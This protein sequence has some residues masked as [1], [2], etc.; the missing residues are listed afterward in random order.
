MFTDNEKLRINNLSY[1]D[2]YN[3]NKESNTELKTCNSTN[4]T[5]MINRIN[6]DYN[7]NVDGNKGDERD[8]NGDEID[9]GGGDTDDGDDYFYD[10]GDEVASDNHDIDVDFHVRA[11]DS[12]ENKI[13]THFKHE[14][15]KEKI[16][17]IKPAKIEIPNFCELK[18]RFCTNTATVLYSIFP[19][20]ETL[21]AKFDKRRTQLKHNVNYNKLIEDDY[22]DLVAQIEVKVLNKDD[23]LKQELK[24]IERD[25]WESDDG[26][27]LV[28]KSEQARNKYDDIITKLRIIS[29]LRKELKF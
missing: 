25:Q 28:P 15:G 11:P 4:A 14:Q 22:L 6:D 1:V 24:K 12:K 27:S 2:V 23:C 5:G 17:I 29:A 7:E 18:P 10:E 26:L 9:N 13:S 16:M 21:I 19:N 8:D 3:E 20:E